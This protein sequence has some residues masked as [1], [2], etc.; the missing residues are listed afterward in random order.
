MICSTPLEKQSAFQMV[1]IGELV[2]H[3]GGSNVV[4]GVQGCHIIAQ[5][6]R[7][8]GNVEDVLEAGC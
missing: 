7:I 3:G 2:E 6:L 5:G 8:A 1:R 4:R